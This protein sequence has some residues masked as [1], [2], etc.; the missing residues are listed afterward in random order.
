MSFTPRTI[1]VQLPAGRA[2]VAIKACSGEF[3][4]LNPGMP[5]SLISEDCKIHFV[6]VPLVATVL[7][8]L[9]GAASAQRVCTER[10]VGELYRI[11]P[12]GTSGAELAARSIDGRTDNYRFHRSGR[13]TQLVTSGVIRI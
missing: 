3:N 13:G 5:N 6:L 10:Q 1:A 8:A 9:A 12:S 2:R 11:N 4:Q 7:L